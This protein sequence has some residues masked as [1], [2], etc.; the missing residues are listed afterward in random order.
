MKI[1]SLMAGYSDPTIAGKRQ[2]ATEA[3]G[4]KLPEAANEPA[5]VGAGAS[6]ALRDI[7]SQY[8]VTSISPREF[9][10]MLQRMHQ[11]GVLGD[12]QFQELSLIRLDLDS[13][14]IG[15]NEK[16]NLV[17]LYQKKLQK[18]L[19]QQQEAAE[20]GNAVAGGAVA[21]EVFQRR[22]EWLQ[23]VVMMQSSPD[24]IGFDLSA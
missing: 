7:V 19:S 20:S 22:L 5:P 6:A 4:S 8:D 1:T 17:D 11:A 10:E 24:A 12:S 23:K 21:L 2:D 18:L 15:A 14:G 13:E 9:S 16:I 3:A